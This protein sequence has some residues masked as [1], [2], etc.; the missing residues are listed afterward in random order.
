MQKIGKIRT[1]ASIIPKAYEVIEIEG[2]MFAGVDAFSFPHNQGDLRCMECLLIPDEWEWTERYI[3]QDADYGT[4]GDYPGKY[5][6]VHGPE[7]LAKL[8]DILTRHETGML[9][10][11]DRQYPYSF[12]INHAYRDGKLY[13][14]SGKSGKKLNL[15]RKNPNACYCIY[16]N[17][18]PV[19]AGVRSCHLEYESILF[20]GKVRISDDP[21]AKEEAILELTNH[22]G[23]PYQHGFANMIDILVFEI[24]YA[25]ARTGRFKPRGDRPIYYV[26]FRGGHS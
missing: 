14:H 16:G 1:V 19:P 26:D 6:P 2:S 15:I 7:A 22:Y 21:A 11:F 23:T 18:E 24:D 17:A 20:Y 10:L 5:R 9:S 12:P 3:I 4:R 13:F 8:E 25:T